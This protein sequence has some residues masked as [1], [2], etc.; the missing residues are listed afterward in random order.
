MERVSEMNFLVIVDLCVSV[1]EA[2][3]SAHEIYVSSSNVNIFF[4]LF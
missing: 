1:D 2:H 4:L 3:D